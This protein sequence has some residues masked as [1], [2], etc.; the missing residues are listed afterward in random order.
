MFEA[1][2]EEYFEKNKFYSKET[3]TICLKNPL[4]AFKDGAEFGFQ[5]GIK[6][7]I[8]TTTISDCPIKDEWHKVADSDLPNH[9]RYVW[10]NVGAGYYDNGW[11][12]DYGRLQGVVAWCEPKF[13]E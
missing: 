12:D 3:G 11:F 9:C 6:A 13:K 1:E 10:T 7:R 2:A 8:N 4:D 5:K